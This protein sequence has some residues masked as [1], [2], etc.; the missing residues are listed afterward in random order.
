ML[1]EL[2]LINYKKFVWEKISLEP[3]TVFVGPNGSGKSTIASAL[4]TIA[5]IMRLGMKSAFPEGLFSFDRIISHTPG[6][7]GYD[8]APIGLGLS[9]QTDG[10]GFDYDIIFLC[11]NSVAEVCYQGLKI[12]GRRHIG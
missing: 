9:G 8:H 12:E 10:F 5:A 6:K 2:R 7:F 11:R 3:I 4:R 1:S